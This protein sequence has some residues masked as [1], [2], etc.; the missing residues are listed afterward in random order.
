[1]NFA[2]GNFCAIFFRCGFRSKKVS[3]ATI[4]SK[5]AMNE[6]LESPFLRLL[7]IIAIAR[8]NG[9]GLTKTL[10]DPDPFNDTERALDLVVV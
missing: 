4:K 2:A 7:P 3:T 6:F 1:M 9:L 8:H 5:M 10:E